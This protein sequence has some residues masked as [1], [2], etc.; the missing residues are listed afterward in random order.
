[1][2]AALPPA[3]DVS[4]DFVTAGEAFASPPAPFVVDD[5]DCAGFDALARPLLPAAEAFAGA[6]AAPSTF[7]A[8][9]DAF[10]LPAAAST[11]DAVAFVFL[12]AASAFPGVFAA[13][14][15]GALAAFT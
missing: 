8:A 7:A 2:A 13:P 10:A 4:A 3:A 1:M 12:A 11:F 15:F 14:S 6:L 9:A 5:C